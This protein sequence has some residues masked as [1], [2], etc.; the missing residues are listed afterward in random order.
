MNA[1][2]IDAAFRDS[3]TIVRIPGAAPATSDSRRREWGTAAAFVRSPFSAP[4]CARNQSGISD[5]NM[6][7]IST[8]SDKRL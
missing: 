7:C 1:T 8:H 4:R 2:A 6:S 5:A 3:L